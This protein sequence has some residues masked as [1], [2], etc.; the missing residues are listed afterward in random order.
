[1]GF[2]L[3]LKSVTLNNLERR[4]G[5]YFSDFAKPVFRL[6]TASSSIELTDQNSA[7]VTHES[8]ELS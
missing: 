2:R 8:G 4:N 1:M 6:I 3:V 5:S 7:S